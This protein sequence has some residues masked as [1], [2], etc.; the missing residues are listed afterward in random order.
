MPGVPI[1]TFMKKLKTPPTESKLPDR[2]TLL[3]L[4]EQMVLLRRFELSA[5]GRCKAGEIAFLHLYVG[6]EAT[7]VGVCANLKNT[8]WVTSTHRGHGHALAKGMSPRALMAELYGKVTGC[9]AGRGGSMHLYDPAIGLFGTNGIVGGGTPSAVG[10]AISARVRRSGQVAVAFFGDGGSNNGSFHE[11]MNIAGIQRAPVV[12]VCEN[13]LYATATALDIATLNTDIASKAAAHGIPGVTVDGNDVLAVWEATRQAV[14]RARA[15]GGPTLIEARTYRTVG[16]NVGDSG[17]GVYRTQEEVDAWKKRDPILNFRAR[18]TDEFK[19][20]TAAELD[21]IEVRVQDEIQEAIEFS[22]SS[23]H[24]EPASAFLHTWHDPINPP[25]PPADL[26]AKSTRMGWLD[27][28]RDAIAEEM[29]RDPNI[30]LF[31]EGI[32]KRGGSFAHTKNLWKEFGDGR[33]IDTP[34]SE[35]GFTGAALGASATGCRAIADMMFIEFLFEATSQVVLQAA[36]LRYMSNGQMT[37]PIIMRAASCSIKHGGPHHSGCYHPMWAHVPGLIV[38]MPSNPAD[39]KGLMKTALRAHDPVIFLE[40]MSLFA[41]KGEV[42]EGEHFVPFGVARIARE[43]TQLTIVT[44]GQHVQSSLDAAGR[45]EKEGISCEVI[46]LR[47][48]VPLDVDTIAASVKK[49]GRLLVV[50]EGYSMCGIGAEI[51]QSMMEMVFD[52]LDAPIGRLHTAPAA[53]PFGP[54]L[55]EEIVITNDKI[56]AAA[57]SVVAG[58]APRQRRARGSVGAAAPAAATVKAVA[59]LVVPQPAAAAATPAPAAPIAG[60]ILTM[61]HGDLTVSEG[62]VVKWYKKVGDPVAVGET[63]V[64][65]E[66]DKAVSFVESPVNGVLARIT[67]SEGT[68]VK[69]GQELGVISPK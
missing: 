66:T 13:N 6:Q 32:A 1:T 27:A 8:D 41:S 53:H 9:C 69:M 60:E 49:T 62:T 67:T 43:G 51:A 54:A 36:K 20:A 22:R 31:G 28:V 15:G 45:L 58:H 33:V 30:I 38:V 63:V 40:P 64:D 46:D 50:D 14:E 37:A 17:V 47:S 59:T 44:C 26:A 35:L 39:A 24:P 21:A 16:H 61:P 52:D 29:R 25:M 19:V 34:I 23:A 57:K 3:R 12:F 10:A 42:P 68:V 7:A 18:L 55:L 5:E 65:I 11:S 56:I 2:N 48:I 4:F